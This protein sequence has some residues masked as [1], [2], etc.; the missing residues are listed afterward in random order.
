MFFYMFFLKFC[1]CYFNCF[2]ILFFKFNLFKIICLSELNKL[3]FIIYKLF[4][5]NIICMCSRVLIVYI[6][7][8]IDKSKFIVCDDKNN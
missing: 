1:W 6:Y 4:L 3:F 5:Y 2:I 7:M 8:Y